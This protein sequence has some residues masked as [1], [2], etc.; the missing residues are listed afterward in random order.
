MKLKE[1]TVDWLKEVYL[2]RIPMEYDTDKF[3]D[4]AVEFFINSAIS[5]TEMFLNI[6]VKSKTYTNEAFDFRLEEWINGF[7]YVQLT[8]RPVLEVTK[9]SLNIITS[10]ITIPPEWIQLKKKSGQINLIPYY[11]SYVSSQINNQALVYMPLI[12][13]SSYLPQIIKCSYSSGYDQNDE[14]PDALADFI[15]QEATISVLN[16]LGEIA[17]GGQAALAGYSIGV[18]G[19]SQSV[20][21]TLSAENTAY[22]ARIKMYRDAQQRLAKVLKDYYYGIRLVGVA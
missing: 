9:M 7:G 14:I 21:T 1:L 13:G 15:G 12:Q 8:H 4:D 17:V 18:D 6:D 3:A 2:W 19:L 10:E 16:V 5:Q 22:S 20:S 11:G